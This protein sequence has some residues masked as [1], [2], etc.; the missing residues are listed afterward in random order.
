MIFFYFEKVWRIWLEFMTGHYRGSGKR[1][2]FFPAGENDG[3]GPRHAK[4][5]SFACGRQGARP[6]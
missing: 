6:L 3:E 4:L 1:D 2:A 5:Y